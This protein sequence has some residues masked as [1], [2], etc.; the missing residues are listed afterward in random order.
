MDVMTQE[1]I[2]Y[3]QTEL[4]LIYRSY[5]KQINLQLDDIRNKIDMVGSNSS[6]FECTTS[7]EK[8]STLIREE[9]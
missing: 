6:P 2:N 5:M 1:I 4:L 8:Q 9:I 3:Y 7:F